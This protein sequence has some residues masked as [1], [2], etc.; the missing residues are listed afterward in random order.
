MFKC[1][2]VQSVIFRDQVITTLHY[3]IW[4][5]PLNLAGVMMDPWNS[6]RLKSGEWWSR[7]LPVGAPWAGSCHERLYFTN[8]GYLFT[9]T[10]TKNTEN[11]MICGV[12]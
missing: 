2:N 11:R 10:Q 9:V 6:E 7:N 4:V 8:R 12:K 3:Q 5:V 1:S